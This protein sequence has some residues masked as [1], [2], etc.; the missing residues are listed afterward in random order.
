MSVALEAD[1]LPLCHRGDQR[2]GACTGSEVARSVDPGHVT[3]EEE[4]STARAAITGTLIGPLPLN[5]DDTIWAERGNVG[6]D[7]F[8]LG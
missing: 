8:L 1:T 3:A 4:V 5:A 2:N 7:F 6:F